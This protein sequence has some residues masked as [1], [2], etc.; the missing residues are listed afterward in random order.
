MTKNFFRWL[1]RFNA[2][3]IGIGIS[4]SLLLM[5]LAIYEIFSNE[6][7]ERR[8]TDMTHTGAEQ[9][10]NT[11]YSVGSPDLIEGQG[12]VVI[13]VL[14]QQRY[15]Q[16]Y[17]SKNSTHN[18]VNYA[19]FDTTTQN[20][21]WLFESSEFL[22]VDTQRLPERAYSDRQSRRTEHFLYTV[23]KQDTNGDERLTQS[24][25]L[26]LSISD[27]AGK[28]YTELFQK[29]QQLIGVRQATDSEIILLF[30]DLQG[31][32]IASISL[33]TYSVNYQESIPLPR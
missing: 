4:L 29:V 18:T 26:T 31:S 19:F 6:T 5:S 8:V 23:A 10:E 13:P 33:D 20:T 30:E 7:R 16:R 9:R 3:G 32:H 27:A 15:T 11:I 22:I 2:I 17:F 12:V 28:R 24:D 1:W 14:A 25:D 21:H